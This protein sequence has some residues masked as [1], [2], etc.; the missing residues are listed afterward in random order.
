VLT[1]FATQLGQLRAQFEG[2]SASTAQPMFGSVLALKQAIAEAMRRAIG[3]TAARASC[4][5]AA[6][7]SGPIGSAAG[8]SIV[9]EA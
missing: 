8:A 5:K 1:A 6:N 3:S 7:R 2:S 4:A 9:S